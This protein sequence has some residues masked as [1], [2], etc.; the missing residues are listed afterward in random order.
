MDAGGYGAAR[1]RN[2]RSKK[3]YGKI[4]TSR[5]TG[6]KQERGSDSETRE[7]EGR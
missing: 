6:S 2:L 7:K 5:K 3:T 1:S 4:N